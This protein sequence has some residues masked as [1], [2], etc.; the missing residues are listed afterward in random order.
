M[1]RQSYANHSC[2]KLNLAQVTLWCQATLADANL[3]DL[4]ID[5][6][7]LDGLSVREGVHSLLADVKAGCGVVNAEDEDALPL[8][9][10]FVARSTLR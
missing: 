5:T 6:T 3:G 1:F 4:G 9:C 10:D 8:V 7:K 2:S